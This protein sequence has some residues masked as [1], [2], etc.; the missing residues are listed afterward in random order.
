MTSYEAS[1]DDA[2]LKIFTAA[3]CVK[4]KFVYES[5]ESEIVQCEKDKSERGCEGENPFLLSETVK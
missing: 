4:D 2:D 3:K 1:C 5:T